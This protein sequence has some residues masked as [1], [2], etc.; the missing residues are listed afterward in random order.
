MERQEIINGIGKRVK[1][2]REEKNLSV[3]ELSK[4]TEISCEILEGIENLEI[5]AITTDYIKLAEFFDV[6]M[7][8]LVGRSDDRTVVK[9]FL[10]INDL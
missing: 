6:N 9:R 7:E 8:Y 10:H 3:E 1:F 4:E 5:V 2:L